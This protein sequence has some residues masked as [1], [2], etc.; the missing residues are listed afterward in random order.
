MWPIMNRL[1]LLSLSALWLLVVGP[2]ALAQTPPAPATGY[3]LPPMFQASQTLPPG[4]LSG[5]YHRVRELA[6]CDGYMVRFT[7]DSDFGTYECVGIRELQRRVREIQ[8]IAALVAVSKSDLFAEG[9]RKSVEAPIDAVK[10]IVSNPG[11]SVR[12]VPHTV[13]HFFKKVG[14]GISNAARKVGE[15]DPS[16]GQSREPGKGLGQAL[17]N[18]A[19]FDKAKLDCARQLGVDPYSDNPRLH[20]E[21]EKVTW[22]FFAGGLPLRVGVAVASSGASQILTATEVVGLPSDIYLETA[23]ELNYRDRQALGPMGVTPAMI[24]AVFANQNLSVSL[25]HDMVQ[26]L[27]KFQG[28]GR[29]YIVELMAACDSVWHA[30]FLRDV[31]HLL[32]RRQA[33]QPYQAYGVFGR[34]AVGVTPDGTVEVPTPVDYVAWTEEVATFATR[35]DIAKMKRRLILHGQLSERTRT[36]LTAAGWEIVPIAAP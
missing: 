13:G 25:R 9:L 6:P 33:A 34:L 3:E 15:E 29:P 11:G 4:L 12:Q 23:S 7:V 20:E 35:E 19:G 1:S 5:P 30:H 26:S 14:S 10:N 21:M 16:G 17:K 32:E 18:V 2:V 27:S 31:L 36:E 24:D 8:A 28:P 22:A